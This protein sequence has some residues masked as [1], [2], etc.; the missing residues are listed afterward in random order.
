MT[1]ARADAPRKECGRRKTWE[2]ERG[3]PEGRR[4]RVSKGRDRGCGRVLHGVL[5]LFSI[6]LF[7]CVLD[8]SPLEVSET[9]IK[10][11][12]D[13]QFADT[14]SYGE[15][16]AQEYQTQDHQPRDGITHNGLTFP[17]QSLLR[18]MPYSNCDP[19]MQFLM[20]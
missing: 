12:F 7:Q 13:S 19:L 14:P 6:P 17:H 8:Q 3:P 11:F 2:E 16:M 20:L 9:V 4:V 15:I 10:G 18:K 5:R 1:S